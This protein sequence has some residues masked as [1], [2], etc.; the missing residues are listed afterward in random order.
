MKT[1]ENINVKVTYYVGLGEIEVENEVFE[2]LNKIYDNDIE[3][4][5]IAFSK[6]DEAIE[7]LRDNI[8]ERD[9]CELEY[10][11]EELS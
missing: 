7:W 3:V 11:I 6:Y 4:D 2:E 5:G 8:K 1:I 10:E 9:C